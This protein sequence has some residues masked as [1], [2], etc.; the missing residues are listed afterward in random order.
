MGSLNDDVEEGLNQN[1]QP[2]DLIQP[3]TSN[4]KPKQ[5]L[6]FVTNVNSAQT[7]PNTD[8]VNIV[9]EVPDPGK[10]PDI[11]PQFEIV[12]Q[13]HTTVTNL[14]QIEEQI[15]GQETI[16]REDANL[17]D[18][19]FG[20]FFNN[21]LSAREF[22]AMRTKTNFP[23]ASRFM[24]ERIA[25]E[26]TMLFNKFKV[27]FEEPLEDFKQFEHHYE[28]Y[29]IPFIRDQILGIRAQYSDVLDHIFESKNVVIPWGAEQKAFI[30]LLTLST[31]TE[32][33]DNKAIEPLLDQALNNVRIVLSNATFVG[34][35]QAVLSKGI[36]ASEW[37]QLISHDDYYENTLTFGDVIK[38]YQSEFVS[39]SLDNML[40]VI[41]AT[42]LLFNN[43][44]QTAGTIET[45]FEKLDDFIVRHVPELKS[46]NDRLQTLFEVAK[47][48]T[49]LNVSMTTFLDYLSKHCL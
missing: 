49:L 15:T 28:H 32:L 1:I 26:E 16:S 23:Y 36:S 2:T 14:K 41:R 45:D 38:F 30:N 20:D 43:L 6:T 39:D 19:M 8:Q 40:L 3:P 33:A 25:Q 42:V 34:Y 12:E 17:I 44:A 35:V 4:D 9:G 31:Q 7:Q 37:S 5:E 21:R 13:G 48:M 27:F 24:R 46:L 18:D 10:L 11:N 47:N 22:T 29:Y